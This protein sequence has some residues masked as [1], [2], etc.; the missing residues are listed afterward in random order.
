MLTPLHHETVKSK[1]R[2]LDLK[3]LEDA[4][5]LTQD[6][7]YMIDEILE[8]YQSRGNSWAR[9]RTM[10]VIENLATA[11]YFVDRMYSDF[12]NHFDEKF[13]PTI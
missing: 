2:P 3:D 13:E 9:D 6:A 12:N 8:E 4:I 1:A 11:S 7:V 10:K 5:E